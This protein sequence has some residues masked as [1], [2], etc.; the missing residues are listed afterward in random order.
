VPEKPQPIAVTAGHVHISTGQDVHML[1]ASDGQ[2]EG[3]LAGLSPGAF[4]L[5]TLVGS[6]FYITS[7]QTASAV[8]VTDNT[9]LWQRQLHSSLATPFVEQGIAYFPGSAILLKAADGSPLQP[10][11]QRP[12]V[13]LIAIGPTSGYEVKG[14]SLDIC[15]PGA[16]QPITIITVHEPDQ[17][18]LWTRTL[19]IPAF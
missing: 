12:S 16:N 1:Q 7:G 4:A 18:A 13:P 19:P 10:L 3:R 8:R 5:A 15:A 2:F 14:G 17:K 11:D 9:V 6:V